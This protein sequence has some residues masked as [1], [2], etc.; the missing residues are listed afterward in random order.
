MKTAQ[1]MDRKD[2]TAAGIAKTIVQA[3]VKQ[4]YVEEDIGKAVNQAILRFA[5]NMR[6]AA[7]LELQYLKI[8]KI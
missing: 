2:S 4:N 3:V 7:R 6:E 1:L 5:E 8:K